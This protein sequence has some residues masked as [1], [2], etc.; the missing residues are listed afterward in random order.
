MMER[1]HVGGKLSPRRTSAERGLQQQQRMPVL[2]PPRLS[3]LRRRQVIS[4]TL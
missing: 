2:L 4:M 1:L 3:P